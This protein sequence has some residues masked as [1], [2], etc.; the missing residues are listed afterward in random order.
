[1]SGVDNSRK[2]ALLSTFFS[3]VALFITLVIDFIISPFIVQNIGPEANGYVQI[4]NN[5]ITIA[6]LITIALNSMGHRMITVAY[7]KKDFK[8]CNKYYSSLFFGNILIVL[9]LVAPAVLLI[10]KIDSFINIV[11]VGVFDVKLLF[12][13]AFINFFVSQFVS[14]FNVGAFARNRLYLIYIATT[15]VVILKAA[16]YIFVFL[17]FDIKVYFITVVALISSLVQLLIVFL[18]K[19][20]LL[21]HLRFSIKDF[22]FK[23]MFVLIKN[24]F[25]NSINQCGNL[26]MTGLDLILTNWFINPLQMGLLSVSKT[27]PNVITTLST[28]LNNSVL[29]HQTITYAIDSKEQYFRTIESSIKLSMLVVV[30]PTSIFAVFA[31]RFYQ[32][33]Q[34][35]LIPYELALLSLL[36]VAALIPL[37]GVQILFNVLTSMNKLKVNAI[38][39]LI[40][41]F[42]NIGIV[43]VLIKFTNLSVYAVAGVSSILSF[44]RFFFI[45]LPYISRLF[46]KKWFCFYKY[47][48]KSLLLFVLIASISLPLNFVIHT[49]WREFAVAVLLS[50]FLGYLVSYYCL[51]NSKERK[52]MLKLVRNKIYEKNY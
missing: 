22:S 35:T 26:L 10:W 8:E 7:H 20:K 47:V 27:M 30:V 25:W 41:G 48:L 31:V 50:L 5:L 46:N 39:F 51:F 44:L 13:F 36:S 14:L 12:L 18:I 45:L 34:P 9:L 19:V 42:L 15:I 37:G 4:A 33:W 21:P 11:K 40:S 28:T 29:S 6:S 24:G 52:Q 32:L 49:N 23:Y 43:L 38:T 2:K 3:L 16:L 1:M 17:I